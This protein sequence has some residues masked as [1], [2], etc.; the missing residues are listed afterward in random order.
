MPFSPLFPRHLLTKEACAHV[1]NP[2]VIGDTIAK[3]WPL[4]LIRDHAPSSYFLSFERLVGAHFGAGIGT[5]ADWPQ[6]PSSA[7]DVLINDE[8]SVTTQVC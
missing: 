3:T 8:N 6:E 7:P 2:I 1:D 4:C 5:A